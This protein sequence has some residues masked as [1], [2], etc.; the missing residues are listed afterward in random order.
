M[1]SGRHNVISHGFPDYLPC[2]ERTI[3]GDHLD[4]RR[5]FGCELP[6]DCRYRASADLQ[7]CRDVIHRGY[8]AVGGIGAVRYPLPQDTLNS[9][10]R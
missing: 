5:V 9:H 6:Q 4:E 10:G 3:A 1:P 2:D 8:L 7:L